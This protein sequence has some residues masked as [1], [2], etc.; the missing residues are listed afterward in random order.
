M[1]NKDNEK[2]TDEH[3]QDQ[4]NKRQNRILKK[5]KQNEAWKGPLCLKGRERLN[6]L[7]EQI[8]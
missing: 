1:N 5:E 4:Q 2:I 3:S 7:E 6:S 8:E